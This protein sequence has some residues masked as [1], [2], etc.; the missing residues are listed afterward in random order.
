MKMTG[1][2]NLSSKHLIFIGYTIAEKR[3]KEIGKGSGLVGNPQVY[4]NGL[5]L[6]IS[7]Q[8]KHSLV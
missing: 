8:W 1:I 3:D 6:M 4:K 7:S 2:I 5:T